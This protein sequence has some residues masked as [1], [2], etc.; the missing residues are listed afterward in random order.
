MFFEQVMTGR[1]S[2]RRWSRLALIFSA[3]CLASNLANAAR[4]KLTDIQA[5]IYRPTYLPNKSL[6][7]SQLRDRLAFYRG[8][9]VSKLAKNILSRSYGDSLDYFYL[10]DLSKTSGWDSTTRVYARL[11]A[12]AFAAQ[13]GKST[14]ELYRMTEFPEGCGR[15]AVEYCPTASLGRSIIELNAA[16]DAADALEAR[17]VAVSIPTSFPSSAVILD[18]SERNLL[19]WYPDGRKVWVSA[20]GISDVRFMTL[21]VGLGSPQVARPRFDR[22]DLIQVKTPDSMWSVAVQSLE[23]VPQIFSY[24]GATT[25]ALARLEIIRRQRLSSGQSDSVTS[26]LD[27][28][29]AQQRHLS[30]LRSQIETWQSPITAD[31][32]SKAQLLLALDKE[33][34][35]VSS[36]KKVALNKI[37][38]VDRSLEE[39]LKIDSYLRST[40]ENLRLLQLKCVGTDLSCAEFRQVLNLDSEQGNDRPYTLF[41]APGRE[42]KSQSIS[43]QEIVRSSYVIGTQQVRNPVYQNLQVEY[44]N[45]M[46]AVEAARAE[47]IRADYNAAVNP[48]FLSGYVQG[49]ALGTLLRAQGRVEEISNALS[50]TPPLV[51]E[52]Q[53][54]P[55]EYSES[56]VKTLYRREYGLV[57]VHKTTNRS[58]AAT[59]AVEEES[60]FILANGRSD[61][62]KSGRSYS[63]ESDALSWLARPRSVY[64]TLIDNA[65]WRSTS[66]ARNGGRPDFAGAARKLVALND[67]SFQNTAAEIVG[68][69]SDNA[70]DLRLKSVVLVRTNNSVGSGFFVSKR[71]IL[72]NAHV[73]G[74][75]TS[76]EIKFSDGRK[77]VG[78][79]IAVDET[80]DLALLRSDAD[81]RPSAFISDAAQMRPGAA[82]DVIGHP[83]GLEFSFSR[84]VVSAI[85]RDFKPAGGIDVI[86]TDSAINPGNSGGPLFI[87]NSV[88]GIVTFKRG[89]SEGLGF[90]VHRDEIQAFLREAFTQ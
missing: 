30:N 23:E 61:S 6:S 70:N 56:R 53:L 38:E 1:T 34:S 58:S 79:V 74:A 36:E 18:T 75:E 87:G 64:K 90:A 62:D 73:I 83:Q 33:S 5:G 68:G 9:D 54:S 32:E 39:I 42:R 78:R 22:T 2:I 76:V 84:G 21:D 82:V 12:I 31:R 8:G 26:N 55:Y 63:S 4:P 48:G 7:T 20:Q 37:G 59:I 77:T 27:L 81:G 19:H 10:A 24:Q 86:Q 51:L 44:Q 13:I 35:D 15:I 28:Y 29:A 49:A 71:N 85:R 40:G 65:S 88:I 43:G 57:L 66:V 60:F 50:R 46:L 47:K 3:L 45:A 16:L 41:V 52:E 72:T 80:R 25:L 14:E 89:L 67:S 17:A 69:R 11:A